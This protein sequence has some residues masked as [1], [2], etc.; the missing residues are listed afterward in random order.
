MGKFRIEK[1]FLGD[2]KV[3]SGAYYGAETQRSK[4]N[5][6]ISRQTMP[7]TFI[8][9]YAMIKR[10]AAI[11]NMKL[12]KLDPSKAKAI[13]KACDELIAGKLADQF[14]IDCF[15]AGAGTSVNMNL[16]E[17]IANRA[18]EI[19]GHKRGNYGI[20]HP[21]DDVN[22]SQ[23]TNDTYHANIHLTVYAE[24]GERLIPS[25]ESLKKALEKK[26]HEF[27]NVVKTGR[28]H[29]QDAVPIT[30]GQ[31]FSGYASSIGRQTGNIRESSDKLLDVSLGG[32]AV[33]TGIEASKKYSYNVT[34][35][36]D[37]LSIEL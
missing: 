21:N 33:G 34:E 13:I 27:S 4:N 22:M 35:N 37:E 26:S 1:D 2:V 23:S 16:N 32:T 14:T 29:L 25:L 12:G 9:H 11:A 20:V 5:Y 19:M 18:I 10:S 30:L 8:R 31:E 6:N 24:L 17:V 15:Q 7:E 36:G 28:T 3:P